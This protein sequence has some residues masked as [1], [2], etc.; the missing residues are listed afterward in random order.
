MDLMIINQPR[1][2]PYRREYEIAKRV[3]DLSLCLLAIPFALLLMAMVSILIYLDSPGHVFFVQENTGKGGRRFRLY[4][5]RT[6]VP[7]AEELKAKY[8]HLNELS[9]P[10]FRITNDPRVTRVGRLLRKT[11][12]DELPQIF[13]VLKG[14]MSLVG[15]RPLADYLVGPAAQA[16]LKGDMSLVGPRPSSFGVD[17]YSLWHTERLEVLPGITGLA[18]ISGRNNLDSREKM[19][20]DIAYVERQ[21]LWLDL[22][23]LARTVRTVL[24]SEGASS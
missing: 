23:I 21:S 6:M 8:A 13:N 14:D 18:Q 19:M 4:K 17:K 7:N 2:F 9:W 11:S 12:L 15:P 16:V 20:L 24:S 5:F 3:M 10:S 1:V 22:Q